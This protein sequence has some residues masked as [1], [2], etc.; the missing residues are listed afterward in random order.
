MQQLLL[1]L[2]KYGNIKVGEKYY[3]FLSEMV[4]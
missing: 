2:W 4:E 1:A 3:Q